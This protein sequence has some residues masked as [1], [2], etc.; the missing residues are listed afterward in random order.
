MRDN[1]IASVINPPAPQ[2]QRD[3]E[4]AQ[5]GVILPP[6]AAW[7]IGNGIGAAVS[8]PHTVRVNAFRW[9]TTQLPSRIF[10]YHVHI[11][12]INPDGSDKEEVSQKEDIKITISLLAKLRRR[13][14]EWDRLPSSSGGRF[15]LG[16]DGRAILCT[17]ASLNLPDRNSS[18]EPYLCE[19]IGLP[20]KND[21]ESTRKRYRISLTEVKALT[22]PSPNSIEWQQPNPEITQLLDLVA[23]S[24][25]RFQLATSDEADLTWITQGTKIFGLNGQNNAPL[26]IGNG[27]LA[28]RGVVATFKSSLAGLTLIAD[29]SVNVF[30]DIGPLPEVM[31]KAAEYRTFGDFYEACRR[32]LSPSDLNKIRLALKTARI[33]TLHTGFDKKIVSL[34]PAADSSETA[35]EVEK[36]RK[37]YTVAQYFEKMC[38]DPTNPKYRAALPKGKL[39]YPKLPLVNVGSTSKP[40]WIP[41]E[42]CVIRVPQ[43]RT[44]VVT[45]QMT[46][47]IIK[48]AAMRPD[49]RLRTLT[50]GTDSIVPVIASDPTNQAFGMSTIDR[51]PMAVD[52]FLLP[53]A[54]LKYANGVVDPSLQGTWNIDR[55][56]MKFVRAPPGP[57]SNGKYKYGILITGGEPRSRDIIKAFWEGIEQ[58]GA[59]FNVPLERGGNPLMADHDETGITQQLEKMRKGGA[60]IVFVIMV[61]DGFYGLIK[62]ASDNMGFVTQC[63]KYKTVDKNPRGLF[64]NILLKVNTK[65]G[66]TNH[67]LISRAT[68]A[69][70]TATG[71]FQDP[72]SSISWMFEK[73][74]MLVGID[75][76]H[77]EPGS[78]K[79]SMAALVAS[80]DG[81]LSQYAAFL[82][83]Q[84]PRKEMVS[85]LEE[86]MATLLQMFKDRNQRFPE[87]IIV[88][89]DG[90][91]DGQYT[92]VLDEELPKL[93]SALELKGIISGNTK[94]S[95]IVCQK[96]HSIR[97]F[98]EEK[99]GRS[100]TY[101]NPCPGLVLDARGGANSIVSAAYNEF[102]LNSHAAIQGTAK[103]CK[104]S[105]IYDENGFRLAELELLTYWTTFLYTRA[106]K[107]VSYATPAYYAHWASKRCKDLVAAGASNDELRQISLK[108]AQRGIATTMFFV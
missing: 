101:I 85:A 56:L 23:L 83:A 87:R 7:R 48:Y 9:N 10:M 41:A 81:R 15:G 36:E 32:G 30:L 1:D 39:E 61:Q 47:E 105:L 63:I 71:Q 60:K 31:R 96:R 88:Y 5:S 74:T 46:S 66:G 45:P 19:M 68:G 69:A 49:E 102:Y 76:S 108:W 103:P 13:H 86:G 82:S 75:V 80:M 40:V 77:P 57:A 26:P 98:Y 21:E 22:L 55:P 92:A 107:S 72:P 4:I 59:A 70:A 3:T 27:F 78:T 62:K 35:F 14:P 65:L 28:R 2:R 54:K 50:E 20:M 91:S 18:R 84:E 79:P 24:F 42:L 43:N 104:Y 97:F 94:I 106:N 11:Y 37:T 34:G 53:A 58:D 38:K 17:N 33:R 12:S 51:T 99:D 93:K 95:I 90:V 64:I 73:A 100:S 25:A 8:S 67:T 52:A 89:R 6:P 44:N 29:I 16:Y